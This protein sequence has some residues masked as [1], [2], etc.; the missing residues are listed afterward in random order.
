MSGAPSPQAS[1][2]ARVVSI[3]EFHLAAGHERLLIHGLGS[4]IAVLLHAPAEHLSCLGHIL[5]PRPPA[6]GSGEAPGRFAST[7]VPAMLDQLVERGAHREGLVAKIA[8][9]AEMFQ[10]E[11]PARHESVGDRNV[12]ATLEVLQR[13]AIPIAARDTGGTHGRTLQVDAG[14][15]RMVI[16]ALRV[17]VKVL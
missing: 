17:E 14:T 2:E 11:R 5:L 15:G 9:G 8:G 12:A 4:C 7:A 1:R 10:Y 6:A 13:L 3:G 16:R